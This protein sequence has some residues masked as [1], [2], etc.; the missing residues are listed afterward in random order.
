MN[1]Y[2]DPERIDTIVT[3]FLSNAIDYTR[4]GGHIR[5][6]ADDLGTR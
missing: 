4:S 6:F 3:N 1:V 2:G 5:V